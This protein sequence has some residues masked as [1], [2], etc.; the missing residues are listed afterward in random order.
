MPRVKGIRNTYSGWVSMFKEHLIRLGKYEYICARNTY[1]GLVR[2]C[3]EHLLRLVKI[4][5][6]TTP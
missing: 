2:L 3:K 1:S 6:G 5:Q 4:V